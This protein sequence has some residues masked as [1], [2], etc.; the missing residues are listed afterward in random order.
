MIELTGASFLD[1]VAASG[2]SMLHALEDQLALRDCLSL[3]DEDVTDNADKSI[4]TS[5]SL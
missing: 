5:G 4:S 3:C 2:T 1:P